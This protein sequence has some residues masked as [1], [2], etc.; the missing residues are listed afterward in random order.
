MP[1]YTLKFAPGQ[2]VVVLSTKERAEVRG[3]YIDGNTA[4]YRI[5][6]KRTGLEEWRYEYELGPDE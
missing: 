5:Q 3:V 1:Q 6:A 2:N 4:Q